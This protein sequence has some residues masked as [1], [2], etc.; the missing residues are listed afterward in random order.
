[1]TPKPTRAQPPSPG[2]PTDWIAPTAPRDAWPV[3]T[4]S[5][6]LAQLRAD[7][8]ANPARLFDFLHTAHFRGLEAL[9]PNTQRAY[10]SDWRGFVR[11]CEHAGFKPLPATPPALEAFIE[12]SLPYQAHVPYKYLLPEAPRRKCRASTLER[13]IAAISAVHEW[14]QYRNPTN[15]PDVA[16]TLRINTRR[17]S[18]RTPKA[19]LPYSAIERALPT[20]GQ[21]L[22][23]L[24]AKALVT[25]AFSTMLRRSELV[26]L[27]VTDF[28]PTPDAQD[29]TIRVR[30]SK[31]DQAG[32]GA[33][34]YVSPEARRHLEAWL[35]AAGLHDGPVF[36]RLNRNAQPLPKAL[37]PNQVALIV[38]D[39]AR[40]AGFGK[41]E[42]NTIA[43][44]STRIGAT[45]AL[46]EAG[47]DVLQ[48]QQ[49]GGW[50]SPQMPATYLRGQ[51]ARSGGMAQWFRAR[52]SRRAK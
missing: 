47:T 3:A 12:Y 27:E 25:L 7:S 46:A 19:P 31:A 24:R 1:M 39:L 41:R 6:E 40:R 50:K 43:A 2:P 21:S 48:V 10:D 14:L 32:H 51:R 30:S 49:D 15:H 36:V 4:S 11:F 34:R 44:H 5:P 37:H 38:K 8:V 33:E 22:S 35:D 42:I 16:H 26:A 52:S 45:H 29:G 20:Y 28:K 9:A 17:R 23:D 13:A 18:A